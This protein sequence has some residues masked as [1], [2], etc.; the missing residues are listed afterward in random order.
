MADLFGD[1]IILIPV[2]AILTIFGLFYVAAMIWS[3]NREAQKH[4]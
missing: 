2:I 4:G 3:Y 1:P